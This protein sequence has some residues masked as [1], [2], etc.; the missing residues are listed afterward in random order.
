ML[1]YSG[2]AYVW[3]SRRYSMKFWWSHSQFYS[4]HFISL[5]E[6]DSVNWFD[7]LL[8]KIELNPQSIFFAA[9]AIKC[10]TRT[11]VTREKRRGTFISVL[12]KW[13]VWK[14]E[15]VSIA[16]ILVEQ[17]C[18]QWIALFT[19]NDMINLSFLW[20]VRF[21]KE[22]GT[23]TFDKLKFIATMKIVLTIYDVHQKPIA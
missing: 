1:F 4:T 2:C 22:V 18:L 10:Q 13:W 21:S 15:L 3:F 19:V 23:E 12:D 17:F 14:R 8:H 11:E 20:N 5:N 16:F 7:C 6:S 9:L